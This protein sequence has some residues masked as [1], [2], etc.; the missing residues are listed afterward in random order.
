MD[1]LKRERQSAGLSIQ[2]LAD[3]LGVHRNTVSGWEDGRF[4]PSSKNIVQLTAIFGCTPDYLLDM[5]DDR[6][7][8]AKV[9]H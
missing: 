9:E 3:M 1:N 2:K 5:T 4:E 8:V 6:H 7:G